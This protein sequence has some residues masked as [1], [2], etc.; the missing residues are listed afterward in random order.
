MYWPTDCD[1]VFVEEKNLTSLHMIRFNTSPLNITEQPTNQ[2]SLYEYMDIYYELS[3]S[4]YNVYL[5]ISVT[6][7][8]STDL[9]KKGKLKEAVTFVI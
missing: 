9:I 7:I 5:I 6:I 4:H 1:G 8:K 3:Y 2:I